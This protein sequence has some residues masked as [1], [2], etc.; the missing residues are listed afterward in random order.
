[1]R[2]CILIILFI[3]GNSLFG[4][5]ATE[6]VV[7]DGTS[8]NPY[9]ITS[10]QNLYWIS[11]S[12]ARWNK[13]YI[14]T[15][16]I[17][18]SDVSPAIN[19]WDSNK[20]WLPIGN[21][22]NKFTGSFNG[23]GFTIN[24]IYLNRSTD[25][26]GLFGLMQGATISNLGVTNVSITGAYGAGGLAG[27]N[28]NSS[29]ISNCYSTGSVS[30]TTYVGGL[31]GINQDASISDSY[32]TCSVSG[33]NTYVGGLV[34]DNNGATISKSYATGNVA[35]LNYIGG[36]IAHSRN[37]ST[38]SNCYSRGNATRISGSG[39]DVGAFVGYN[40]TI[41]RY[42]YSTGTVIYSGGTNP[43]DK[44]FVGTNSGGTYT[45]N[46]FDNQTSS[47]TTGS[48]ATAK[49]TV[50]MQTN[51]TFTD[52]GWDVAIWNREDGVNDDYPYLDW[53]NTS[54][55]P[56]PVE[57]TYF[58][59]E[60]RVQS[61]MADKSVELKWTTATEVNNYGFNIERRE[62]G[63][64]K[65]E[66]WI[67]IGFVQGY[68]NSNSPKEYFFLDSTPPS[69]KIH[70]RLKQIDFDGQFEYSG[71][72]EVI[73][74]IPAQFSL[75]QNYPNPFNPI[76]TIKYSIPNVGTGFSLSILKVYDILG[77]EVATLVNEKQSAGNYEVKFDGSKLASGVYFY[78]LQAGKYSSI[79]KLLLIK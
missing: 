24:G 40:S 20:G 35:G 22:T 25:W 46:F 34:G 48:G 27:D 72:V 42:C 3:W 32:S 68:G 62:T 5:T 29:T 10:W 55:T 30:G 63:N 70:Y 45:S 7:G 64:G 65:S 36:L 37:S 71:I 33:T 43:T 51:T 47:Q 19:T 53:Q 54:G 59:A 56:L 13:H 50:Q 58:S 26:S 18:F 2:K 38:V 60:Y 1:M 75:K 9:Q 14:Q 49:T 6:P 31:V 77:S 76:T 16:N 69:G 79:R 44:G 4:Q 66:T 61:A 15:Q 8:G 52:A 17:D 23:Q 39:T 57:L 78:K 28:Y 74:D 73:I 11:Q 41:T 12:T 67:K 21:A